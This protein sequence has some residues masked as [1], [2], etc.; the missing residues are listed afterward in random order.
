[1]TE[2]CPRCGRFMGQRKAGLAAGWMCLVCFERAV[3]KWLRE[4]RRSGVCS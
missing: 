3:G 4:L 2:R 1:M